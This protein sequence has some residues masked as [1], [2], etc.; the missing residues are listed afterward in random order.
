MAKRD[1]NY[2]VTQWQPSPPP[3]D[4][5]PL[6]GLPAPPPGTT[7]AFVHEV[8]QK[9]TDC[10]GTGYAP[11]GPCSYHSNDELVAGEPSPTPPTPELAATFTA[12]AR[13]ASRAEVL[14]VD[15]ATALAERGLAKFP[16]HITWHTYGKEWPTKQPPEP[17][18]KLVATLGPLALGDSFSW[19]HACE[20][21]ALRRGQ[22]ATVF[23]A[24]RELYDL[25]NW[26]ASIEG[27]AVHLVM[28]PIAT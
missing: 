24:A 9:C 8:V 17:L 2:G 14:G 16:R 28:F 13:R 21:A 7:R 4:D 3:P 12:M 15:I 23:T 18:T 10:R 25:G 6:S 5:E 22:D 20:A 11:D 19:P 27:E 26:I 1:L